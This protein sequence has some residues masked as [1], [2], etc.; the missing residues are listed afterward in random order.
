MRWTVFQVFSFVNALIS[1]LG[2]DPEIRLC[3]LCIGSPHSLLWCRSREGKQE[4]RQR[5]WRR[6]MQDR[7]LYGRLW[8]GTS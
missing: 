3:R 6:A 2:D 5:M 4:N 1:A 7:E 8:S